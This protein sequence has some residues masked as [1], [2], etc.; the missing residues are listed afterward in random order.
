MIVT[1]TM[2]PSIDISYPLVSWN[3]DTVNRTDQVSK[4]A[5]G[6]GL[7]VTRV[8]HD[9]KGDV[10]AT[11]VLGGFHGAFIADELKRA[12]IKQKFTDIKEESRDS[13]AILHEGNQTEI[14]EAGPTVSYEEQ[15]DF[16]ENFKELIKKAKIVTISGSLAKGLP[17][18]FYQTLVQLTEE[19]SIKVLV[20]TSGESLRQVLAGE[21]KPFLIKPNLE[22][23]SALLRYS[24]SID[25][26]EE[27][28]EGLNQPIFAGIEWIVVS[29][30]KAG[31]FAKHK[32]CFYRVTLPTIKAVNPVGSGDATV[33]GFAYGLS[34][35]MD[36]I[37]LLKFCMATGMSNAQEGQTGHVALANVQSH[38]EKITVQKI[39]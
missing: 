34:Q 37:E 12:G 35:E 31:A 9:L 8:I 23:L 26:L 16:L 28:Q 18:N 24:F 15:Q 7:N 5:G 11:G 21:Q 1:I 2:N 4:T 33:A 20:D 32:D 39:E 3:V 14:L 10:L 27:L 19:Q 22:E 36:E 6:K 38:I 30:G 13:I 29:L 25:R 17:S